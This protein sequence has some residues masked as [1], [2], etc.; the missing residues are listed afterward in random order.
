[1]AVKNRTQY[2]AMVLCVTA[3]D[4]RALRYFWRRGCITTMTSARTI[5]T[6]TMSSKDFSGR[7]TKSAA[8][9]SDPAI[10]AGIQ[11]LSLS[12]DPR[13]SS[14]YPNDEA[15]FPGMSPSALLMVAAWGGTPKATSAGKVIRVPE[16]TTALIVPAPSPARK[17]S[18]LV[19]RSNVTVPERGSDHRQW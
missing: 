13:R 15:I 16:P 7:I 11:R 18:V 19:S 17:M 9:I 3:L 14:R 4:W 8:P 6:G 10:D 5:R 12:P 1:M 2:T